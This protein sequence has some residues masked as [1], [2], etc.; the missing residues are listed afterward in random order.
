SFAHLSGFGF[1]TATRM[2]SD[3]LVTFAGHPVYPALIGL[4][5]GAGLRFIPAR[6][7][8][9][10]IPALCV[11]LLATFDHAM[12][13]WKTLQPDSPAGGFTDAP[14]IVEYLYMATMHGR[15]E[16]WLLPIGLVV[17]EIA[18]S[19]LCAKAIGRRP[20]LLLRFELGPWAIN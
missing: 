17:A 1:E 3:Y 14:I 5:A 18:E 16:T 11:F 10:W 13:N 8:V 6:R 9:N 2:A 7:D 12:F 20:D 4:A 19:W 15:L